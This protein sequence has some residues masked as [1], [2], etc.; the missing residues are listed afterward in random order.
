MGLQPP[1]VRP[2]A[3]AR[4]DTELV[5]DLARH[6]GLGER[7][8]NGDISASITERLR[9]SG[10]RF[11]DLPKDGR[12]LSIEV[13]RPGERAYETKGFGTPTGKVEIY[14]GILEKLGYDPLPDYTEPDIPGRIG[15]EMFRITNAVLES[16]RLGKPI[17]VKR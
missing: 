14:S 12:S 8:W 15:L 3:E 16:S 1:A 2:R 9:G 7:F 13:E 11:E 6:L 10:L 5:F 17:K 4:G